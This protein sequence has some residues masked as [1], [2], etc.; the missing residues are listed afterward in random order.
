MDDDSKNNILLGAGIVVGTIFII[1]FGVNLLNTKSAGE[2][3]GAVGSVLGGTIGAVGAA[4]AVALT[5]RGQRTEETQMVSDA[6]YREVTAFT[7]YILSNI[8]LCQRI[9]TGPFAV[10]RSDLPRWMVMPKSMIYAAVADKIARLP[11]P[12]VVVSFYTRLSEAEVIVNGIAVARRLNPPELPP[13]VTPQEAEDIVE[14]WITACELAR[15][16]IDGRS[17]LT[18]L[19]RG[20]KEVTIENI[21]NGLA[22]ARISFPSAE[23]FG[24]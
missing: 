24:R 6:V 23:H 22:N 15:I 5:L 9:H 7:T 11:S 20:V 12:H 2:I 8:D 16:I 10:P 21:D 14:V 1:I 18:E 17:P 4:V 13:H 3:A 19:D